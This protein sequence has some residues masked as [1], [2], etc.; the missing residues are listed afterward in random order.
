[1]AQQQQHQSQAPEPQQQSPEWAHLQQQQ[2]Q[3]QRQQQQQHP[4]STTD[5]RI[6]QVLRTRV[7]RILL[8]LEN[9][10]DNKNY[11][12]ILR[13]CDVLGVQRVWVIHS[14]TAPLQAD[15]SDQGATAQHVLA[16]VC[17]LCRG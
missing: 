4:N 9:V 5:Q 17:L 7:D 3:P 1:M 8:V 10:T 11:L 2:Q 6:A 14:A 12:A 15:A 16:Q 13:T